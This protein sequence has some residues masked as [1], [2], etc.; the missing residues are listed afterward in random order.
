[1]GYSLLLAEQNR[2]VG[3][4]LGIATGLMFTLPFV[5]YYACYYYVFSNMVDP[6]NWSGGAAVLVTNIIIMAYVVV[7]FSEPDDDDDV[8]KR[9]NA[10]HD[11]DARHPRTG[12]FKRRVD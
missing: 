7:A 11:N 2:D 9:G 12:I 5:T 8:P 6:S 1:M 3:R 4:K 10:V